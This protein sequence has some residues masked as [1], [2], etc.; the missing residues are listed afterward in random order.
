MPSGPI[1]SDCESQAASDNFVVIP[2]QTRD[3]ALTIVPLCSHLRQEP[4]VEPTRLS[5]RSRRILP[6]RATIGD[7]I[8]CF[9]SFVGILM[10]GQFVLMLPSL[11]VHVKHVVGLNLIHIHAILI[12]CMTLI[13]LIVAFLQILLVCS[14]ILSCCCP[15]VEF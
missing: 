4:F 10:L 13:V 1:A 14:S 5:F 8:P 9:N 11:H 3:Y 6:S 2:Y 12:N 7:K 15:F